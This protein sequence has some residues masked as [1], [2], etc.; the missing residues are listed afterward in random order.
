[1]LEEPPKEMTAA[2]RMQAKMDAITKKMDANNAQRAIDAKNQPK[3]TSNAKKFTR[4]QIAQ[5]NTL[6]DC[7]I[8][9]D[10]K[11]YSVSSHMLAHPGG[12]VNLL[13]CSG[14]GKDH[15]DDFE[16]E[17]HSQSAINQLRSFYI[18]DVA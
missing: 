13:N 10:G 12:S 5:H 8:I 11:V 4:G 1:M 17:E 14:D 15:I 16:D 9:L 6:A 18:G 3:N 7:W 2:E